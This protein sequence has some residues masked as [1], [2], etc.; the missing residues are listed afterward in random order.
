RGRDEAFGGCQVIVTGDFLQLPPVKTNEAGAYDWA[1]ASEGWRRAGFKTVALETVKRQDEVEFIRALSN[2]R[3]GRIWGDDARLLQGRIKNFPPATLTR[4]FTHNVQ[5]D[6][7][8]NFQ[9]E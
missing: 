6:R 4:L 7:W 1:F 9:L 5:V 2:F 3:R 8:T